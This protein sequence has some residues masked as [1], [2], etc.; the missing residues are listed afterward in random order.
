MNRPRLFIKPLLLTALI[1]C[2]FSVSFGAGYQSGARQTGSQELYDTAK[3]D[4][5]AGAYRKA[6]DTIE[7]LLKAEPDY[8]PA[9]LLK[10]RAFIGLS[11]KVPPLTPDEMKSPDRSRERKMRQAGLL[12]EAADS[13][14]RFLQ[15]KPETERAAW[16]REQLEALRVYAEPA[17]KPEAEWTVFSG[18]EVTEKAHI[19]RRPQPRYPEEARGARLS[20]KV[21]L[22][23][24]LAA[25]GTVKHVL[26]LQPSHQPLTESAIEAARNIGFEPA[27][28]DG[29][30]VSTALSVEYN[31][32][33]Y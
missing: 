32:M 2:L 6:L 29:H 7:E 14:E 27:I 10:A 23:V 21:K 19:T 25:D 8:A 15:L 4:Y 31:F 28:K 16:L 26:V 17:T 18:A 22:L 13:L 5:E 24:V 3:R 1:V 12:K 9:F 33:T 30:P 20:G 11:M